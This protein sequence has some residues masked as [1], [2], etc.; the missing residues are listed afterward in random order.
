MST[1]S[2]VVCSTPT[3]ETSSLGKAD[4]ERNQRQFNWKQQFPVQIF[5][6]GN[7]RSGSST[8]F[9]SRPGQVRSSLNTGH[10]ATAPACRFRA[11]RRRISFG[12]MPPGRGGLGVNFWN[13]RQPV[14]T[15]FV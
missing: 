9:A 5:A 1:P 13:C 8:D 6:V 11:R 4:A 7:I 3:D 2:N 14:F 15:H 12:K 10:A